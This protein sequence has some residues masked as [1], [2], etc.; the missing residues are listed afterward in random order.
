VPVIEAYGMT[1]AAHQMT[2]NPLPEQPRKAGTVGKPAGSEVAVLDDA[3]RVLPHGAVGEIAIKGP[4]V[5]AGYLDNPAANA[6]TFVNGWFRTGDQG[7]FDEDGYLTITG[8]LKEII[9]R[10]GEK[11]APREIDEALLEHADVVHAAAFAIPHARL[12]EEVAAAVVLRDGAV[13]TAPELRVFVGERLAPFKVPRRVVVVDE[14][15]R[16]RTGKLER[17]NLA[18]ML[19][20]DQMSGT[21]HAG[22]AYVPPSDDIE[23]ELVAI[24]QSVLGTDEPPSIDVDFFELGGDSLH[25]TEL[26]LDIEAIFGRRLAATTLLTGATVQAMASA[27][28]ASPESESASGASVVPVQPIGSKPPLFCLLRGGSV[29]TVRHFANA[30]GPDQ[31]TYA[32]WYPA[33]HGPPDA[34]GSVEEIAAT[35]V[36]AVL[37]VRREGPYF[38]FG[39]SLGGLVMYETARQLAARGHQ[40]GLVALADSP[41]PDVITEWYR[42]RRTT[43]YRVRK[44]FSSKGPRMV[45]SRIRH[46]LGVHKPVEPTYVPG[47]NM[48]ADYPAAMRRERHYAPGP[49]R[50]PVVILATR[51]Q[52]ELA[53]TPDLGWAPLLEAGWEGYEVPGSHASMIGEPYVHVLAARLAACLE[54][55]NTSSVEPGC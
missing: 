34:A 20:L 7:C 25:A 19:G 14:L 37:A 42:R 28:R 23:R 43:R 35:C 2:S 18:T 36:D 33:M 26:F 29:V 47:T 8:R 4:T 51:R 27:L 21:R 54:D 9:N 46:A 3:G 17:S 53:G 32:L 55:A 1:E 15:P 5:T 31:P 30:L 10:G 50:G 11:V 45:A 49:A 44:L 41:H 48:R 38:L 13:V 6:A 12:G 16:G 22:T 24:W 39:H 40:I 52:L